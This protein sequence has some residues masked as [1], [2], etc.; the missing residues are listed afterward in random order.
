MY[1]FNLP[2]IRDEITQKTDNGDNT[3]YYRR[4]EGEIHFESYLIFL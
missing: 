2:S 3:N 4:D 1:N